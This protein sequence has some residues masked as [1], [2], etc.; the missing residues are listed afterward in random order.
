MLSINLVAQD[1]SYYRYNDL[2]EKAESNQKQGD[3]KKALNNYDNAFKFINFSPWG[4]S[5]AFS[6]AISDSNFYK[7]NEYLNLGVE[8][9]LNLSYLSSSEIRAF[10]KSKFA[11]EF[12]RRKDSLLNIFN[13]S[14]DSSYCNSIKEIF[15][16]DQS[17][18]GNGRI[19]EEIN[20]SIC[21]D[22]IIVLTEA[23]GFA[24]IKKTSLASNTVAVILF[25]NG[26]NGYP[27]SN[28]WKKIIP[29]IKKEIFNGTLDPNYLMNL[30]IS[31]RKFNII[32]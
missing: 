3:F 8:K 10:N 11:N 15:K 32:K 28:Q 5:D 18:R 25:H 12:W 14:I 22:R 13:S 17:I 29:F 24:T 31:Y 6:A 27:Y 23:K 21:F 20:D 19:E 2:I 7:A 26:N 16:I 30:E 9:G 1:S 4:Y